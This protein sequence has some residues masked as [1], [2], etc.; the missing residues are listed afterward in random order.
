VKKR[1]VLRNESI[2]NGIFTYYFLQ[3]VRVG[4]ASKLGSGEDR[5][6]SD[7]KVLKTKVKRGTANRPSW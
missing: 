6:C 5:Q 3:S 7:L 4:V 1:N 2:L